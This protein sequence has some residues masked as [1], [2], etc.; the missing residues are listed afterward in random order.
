MKST[1]FHDLAARRAWLASLF[2][3]HEPVLAC[4]TLE[5]LAR[6]DKAA[7][8]T[9]V[10]YGRLMDETKLAAANDN[11]DTAPDMRR[12]VRPSVSELMEAAASDVVLSFSSPEEANSGWNIRFHEGALRAHHRGLDYCGALVFQN[13]RL[14]SWGKTKRGAP[15]RP[16][17]RQRSPRGTAI[18]PRPEG[19]VRYLLPANDNTPIASGANF[20]AGVKG[21]KG[22][23]TKPDIGE[24]D[25]AEE[26]A[27]SQVRETVR[28]RLGTHGAVLDAALSD[29]TAR[30]IGEAFGFKGKTAERRGI[31]AI[32]AALEEFEKMAA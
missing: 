24:H 31:L 26:L 14:V 25:A 29:A 6:R 19:A 15:L 28:A 23:T 17:E 18:P 27:R 8:A 32:R 30:D 20:L 10:R 4:P 2:S 5:R 12:E 9:L 7:A 11:D 3:R 16:V 1:D 22:N 13:G 21:K